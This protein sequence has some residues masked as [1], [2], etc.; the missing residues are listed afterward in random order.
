MAVA[1]ASTPRILDDLERILFCIAAGFPSN[2]K[3][4]EIDSY[5]TQIANEIYMYLHHSKSYDP[6]VEPTNP[7]VDTALQYEH[8]PGSEE[9]LDSHLGKTFGL[10]DPD[11][12]WDKLHKCSICKTRR[13]VSIY[14][15]QRHL[16]WHMSPELV[17]KAPNDDVDI[18]FEATPHWVNQFKKKY[19]W[20]RGKYTNVSACLTSVS[21]NP[22]PSDSSISSERPDL[23]AF[24][25]SFSKK[26]SRRDVQRKMLEQMT[27]QL[28]E[29]VSA[30]LWEEFVEKSTLLVE[31][32][33]K[34][35][36]SDS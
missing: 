34:K 5:L 27:Q 4:T 16:T 25:T 26:P 33:M 7:E 2:Y 24:C 19:L 36:P 17:V 8:A 13:F 15:L 9:A 22:S 30:D 32:F 11:F 3:A 35:M 29:E 28:K 6:Q 12:E 23:S 31:N 1:R 21:N 18:N 14:N 20:P 10:I